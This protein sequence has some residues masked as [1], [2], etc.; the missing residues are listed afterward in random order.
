[1]LN[2]TGTANTLMKL[3]CNESF[4]VTLKEHQ[5]IFMVKMVLSSKTRLL[6]IKVREYIALKLIFFHIY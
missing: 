3:K 5:T 4:P 2:T 1:M 6:H